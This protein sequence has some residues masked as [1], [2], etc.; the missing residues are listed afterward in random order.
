MEQQIEF[1]KRTKTNFFSIYFPTILIAACPR[2]KKERKTLRQFIHLSYYFD[3]EL[4]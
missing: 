1:D 3:L 4:C 2:L